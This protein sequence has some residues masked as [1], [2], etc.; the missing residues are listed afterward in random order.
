MALYCENCQILV[1]AKRCPGCG[2]K[3]VREPLPNDA[4]YLCEKQIAWGEMLREVL[5]NNGIPTF[6]KKRLGIGIALR[7]GPMMESVRI[8]VPYS[9]LEEASEI[10]AGLFSET[11]AEGGDDFGDE[12]EQEADS[13]FEEDSSREDSGEERT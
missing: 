8:F 1:E 4:C 5:E 13:C 11:Y 7:V 12:A 10:E 3:K 9:C 6:F 2:S